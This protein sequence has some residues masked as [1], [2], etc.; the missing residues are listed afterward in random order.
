MSRQVD[1][2]TTSIMKVTMVFA[3]RR[4]AETALVN[5]LST[6]MNLTVSA[7]DIA[8]IGLYA[9]SRG[10]DTVPVSGII[11]SQR[12]GTV[13]LIVDVEERLVF[14]PSLETTYYYVDADPKN[15][16]VEFIKGPLVVIDSDPCY[17]GDLFSNC[18]DCVNVPAHGVEDRQCQAVCKIKNGDIQG[19]K[20]RCKRVV[21][22]AARGDEP[23]LCS[24]HARMKARSSVVEIIRGKPSSQSP[25][26]NTRR[27]EATR[28]ARP[29]T[30]REMRE[31]RPSTARQARPSIERP[32]VMPQP[33]REESALRT[34]I[35]A[36]M[37]G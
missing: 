9:S 25:V 33:R 27:E 28:Q 16:I 20:R 15:Q 36:R 14:L 22:N 35:K 31:A 21:K 4:E 23:V 1:A 37:L 2:V 24:Q 18:S 8:A 10:K 6:N 11:V 13:E 19:A 30:A 26:R 3:D 32:F 29:S 17:G 34:R 7:G 5:E 12:G